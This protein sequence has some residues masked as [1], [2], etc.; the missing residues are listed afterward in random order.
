MGMMLAFIL[1]SMAKR[2][3]RRTIY[4]TESTERRVRALAREGESFSAA[5]TRLL[6]AG[7]AEVEG[8]RVPSYVGVGDGPPDELGRKVEQ[9]LRELVALD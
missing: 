2:M 7:A 6:E 9:Y 3:P 8:E 5:V 1:P 4:I